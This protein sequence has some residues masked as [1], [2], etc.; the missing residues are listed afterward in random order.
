MSKKQ[1]PHRYSAGYV[2]VQTLATLRR[3]N[4]S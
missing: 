3:C 4:C 1:Q 2:A